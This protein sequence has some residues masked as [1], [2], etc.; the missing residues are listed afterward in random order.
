DEHGLCLDRAKWGLIP[1]W[2]KDISIS[3]KFFYARSETIHEKPS[4]KKSFEK[5]RCLIPATEF[6]EWKKDGNSKQPYSIS[7]KD[8][9]IFC[10]GGIWDICRKGDE[11]IYSTTIITT[12]PNLLVADIHDRMPVIIRPD[13]YETWIGKDTDQEMTFKL[14][15]PF[16]ESFM[17]AVPVDDGY[18]KIP[19][20]QST[21]ENNLFD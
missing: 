6:F 19:K 1:S 21:K 5:R 16:D 7:M 11:T 17:K 12:L 4:F 14:M 13:M 8:D 20:M 18:F 3:N 9:S 10:F 15:K 2:A